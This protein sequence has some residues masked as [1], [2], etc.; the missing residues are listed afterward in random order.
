M[1]ACIVAVALALASCAPK[2][3]LLPS[4]PPPWDEHCYGRPG[5]VGRVVYWMGQPYMCKVHADGWWFE[6]IDR[7]SL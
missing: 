6:Q 2:P 7:D 3:Q 1:R 5:D 4:E